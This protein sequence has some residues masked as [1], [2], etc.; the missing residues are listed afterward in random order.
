MV[1]AS[2]IRGTVP[3]HLPVSSLTRVEAFHNDA[4][5]EF[6]R[7]RRGRSVGP[8]RHPGISECVA[9]EDSAAS[10]VRRE[11]VGGPDDKQV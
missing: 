9:R 11:L 7:I 6:I 10:R 2:Q 5:D 8:V 1:V 4:F 3:L